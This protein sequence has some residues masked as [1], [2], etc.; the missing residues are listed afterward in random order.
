MR[1]DDINLVSGE[2]I[3]KQHEGLKISKFTFHI[4][5]SALFCSGTSFSSHPFLR[6]SFNIQGHIGM[7]YSCIFFVTYNSSYLSIFVTCH[8]LILTQI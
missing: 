7:T 8:S 3:S 1:G 6:V 2:E 5:V 4:G